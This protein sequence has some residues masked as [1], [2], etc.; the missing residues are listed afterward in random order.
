LKKADKVC[1]AHSNQWDSVPFYYYGGS[2]R[3]IDRRMNE[4]D[5]V[6]AGFAADFKAIT[7]PAK[8]RSFHKATV[9]DFEAYRAELH[10]ASVAI[11]PKTK[12]AVI[13]DRI[14][15][16]EAAVQPI[17]KRANKRFNAEHLLR[18]GSQF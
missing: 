11:T 9:A 6:W 8:W 14:N 2:G 1:F 15:S 17:V 3:Q 12:P 13:N 4:L 7:P 16:G 18:C 5:A 10:K